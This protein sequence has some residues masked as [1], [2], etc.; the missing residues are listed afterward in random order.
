MGRTF[1]IFLIVL[2]IAGIYNWITSGSRKPS[3]SV[4]FSDADAFTMASMI[5]ARGKVTGCGDLRVISQSPGRAI[6]VECGSGESVKEYRIS[7]FP[8]FEIDFKPVADRNSMSGLM[9]EERLARIHCV[10]F[11]DGTWE[12]SYLREMDAMRRAEK[13]SAEMNEGATVFYGYNGSWAQIGDDG[14]GTWSMRSGDFEHDPQGY[15]PNGC[16]I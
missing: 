13:I 10:R 2:T 12:K 14:D 9:N 16:R 4:N 8:D 11:P 6:R 3:L 1:S 15:G 7:Y 5:L